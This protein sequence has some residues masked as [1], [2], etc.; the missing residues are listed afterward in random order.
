MKIVLTGSTGFIGTEIL[1]QAIA[2]NYVTH[3]YVLTRRPLAPQFSHKKVTQLLHEDFEIYPDPLLERLREEGVCACIW[4]LGGKVNHFKT[5]DEAR[6]TGVNYP[7][8]A[9]E[10]FAKELA[11]ALK[12]FEGYG[13]TGARPKPGEGR[14]PFR[15]VFVSGWGAEQ[16]QFKKLWFEN[17][18][19]KIKGAAERALLSVADNSAEVGGHHCFEVVCLRPG[20]VLAGSSD[21]MTTVITEAIVPSI[22]VDRLAKTA[23]RVVFNGG[24]DGKTIMENKDCLGDDWAMVNSFTM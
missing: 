12:P 7:A 2:H 10:V 16:D 6:K 22:A 8:A 11:P 4:A 3:V 24:T 18:N 23:I 5:I 15:F 14:F 9:A 13:K 19:R 21:S 20:G 1:T 17:E